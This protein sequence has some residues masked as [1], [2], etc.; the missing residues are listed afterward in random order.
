MTVGKESTAKVT[1]TNNTKESIT[2]TPEQV[3]PENMGI[4]IP[5]KLVLKP[6][7]SF[8]VVAKVVPDKKGYFNCSLKLK[9]NNP[10][11]ME[12]II[13]GYGNVKESPLFNN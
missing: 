8:E 5:K 10:D 9:T 6:G 4:N 3:V 11:Q 7:E 12:I 1:I 13:P 2:I